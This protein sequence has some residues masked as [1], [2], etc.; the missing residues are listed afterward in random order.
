LSTN[1]EGTTAREFASRI[2]VTTKQWNEIPLIPR[3][4]SEKVTQHDYVRSVK[5][6]LWY[7]STLFVIIY[8]DAKVR[9]TVFKIAK[10]VAM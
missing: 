1:D 8:S 10:K 3:K 6:V 5:N 2:G 4:F 7:N 9:K